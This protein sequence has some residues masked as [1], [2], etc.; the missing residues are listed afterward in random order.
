[1]SVALW[2]A[3]GCED[4]GQA[5]GAAE[6]RRV[7]SDA[8]AELR[9][10]GGTPE[11]LRD[12]GLRAESEG[13]L[14]EAADALALAQERAPNDFETAGAL[15]RIYVKFDY[16]EAALQQLRICLVA[17]P[18]H[19]PC[20]LVL[21]NVLEKDG[22]PEALRQAQQTLEM[23][24][25][26]ADNQGDRAASQ[27]ALVSVRRKLRAQAHNARTTTS[28]STTAEGSAGTEG[29]TPFGE[30]IRDGF[31]ARQA[32]QFQVAKGHFERAIRANPTN[33]TAH[34]GLIETLLDLHD[35]AGAETAL[36]KA[37]QVAGDEPET[38]FIAGLVAEKRGDLSRTV[39]LWE[40]LAQDVPKFAEQIALR[41]RI[42]AVRSLIAKPSTKTDQPT[43]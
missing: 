12:L 29:L 5:P 8:L 30:A 24:T 4:L 16:M 25:A 36:R 6:K 22:T 27:A 9:A 10:N 38:R 1:L 40:A 17:K 34:A 3:A 13:Q 7:F 35:W 23:L 42:S 43:P 2:L 26:I 39:Q 37:T 32:Q 14:F 31:A 15:S 20:L 18:R 21:A 11:A 28:G 19:V 33:A 41:D